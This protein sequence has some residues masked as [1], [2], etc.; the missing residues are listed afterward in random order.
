MR[1][2]IFNFLTTCD[3]SVSMNE[4][5]MVGAGYRRNASP[6]L[7]TSGLCRVNE[8][9]WVVEWLMPAAQP[10]F[11]SQRNCAGP[12]EVAL[13]G[14]EGSINPED[15]KIQKSRCCQRSS[16]NSGG[17]WVRVSSHFATGS[18]HS[19]SAQDCRRHAMS[20]LQLRELEAYYAFLSTFS[21]PQPIVDVSDLRDGSALFE[22]LSTV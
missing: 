21:L 1:S 2:W 14:H 15:V 12:M 17:T 5:S 22:V 11:S 16:M 10:E 8:W 6:E 9:A 4:R 19:R 3:T 13:C 7:Y 20:E 18:Y